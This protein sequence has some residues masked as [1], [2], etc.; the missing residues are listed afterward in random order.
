ME[1]PVSWDL[2]QLGL[3]ENFSE[4]IRAAEILERH[5]YRTCVVGDLVSVVYGSDVVVSDVYIAVADGALRSALEKL[6]E[7][8]YSEEAQSNLRFTSNTPAKDSSSGWP[9]YRLR[10]PSPKAVATGI[11]LIPSSLWHLD[12]NESSFL[13]D[14]LL[15][16]RSMCRFPRLEPYLN[17][18]IYTIVQR[19]TDSSLNHNLTLY[20]LSQYSTILVL[21]PSERLSQLPT[22][23]QFFVQFFHKMLLPRSKIKFFSLWRRVRDGSLSVSDAIA[24]LPRQDMRIA[25]MKARQAEIAGS[26][27]DT[28]RAGVPCGEE[29]PAS[30]QA[31]SA[32]R[33]VPDSVY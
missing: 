21:L 16:P 33:K 26:A 5:G 4:E 12:V 29:V 6:L 3:S 11:L 13:S 22:E 1:F 25:E 8:G 32:G 24:S 19:L 30:G 31:C 10:R 14:T 20:I 9:G 23:S 18:L 2:E 15:F 7:H 28:V 27:S 17:A